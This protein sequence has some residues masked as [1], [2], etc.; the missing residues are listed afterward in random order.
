MGF[1]SSFLFSCIC[2]I[3]SPCSISCSLILCC[4]V[5]VP[6]L[7]IRL[8]ILLFS[9]I[10]SFLSR[11]IFEPLLLFLFSGTCRLQIVNIFTSRI[12]FISSMDLP[13]NSSC[14]FILV[15][16]GGECGEW[17]TCDE[18]VVSLRWVMDKG[19]VVSVVSEER[20]MSVRWVWGEWLQVCAVLTFSASHEYE[21]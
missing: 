12:K 20:V 21:L 1:S 14:Q 5:G 7:L 3:F 19:G 2:N 9:L 10:R 11:G 13:A 15:R 8:Y 17:G 4:C 18:C 6:S 16:G